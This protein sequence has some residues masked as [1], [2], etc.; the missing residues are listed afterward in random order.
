M[1]EK[2]KGFLS[3]GL[4]MVRVRLNQFQQPIKWIVIGYLVTVFLFVVSYYGFWMYLAVTGKIQLRTFWPWCG[5]W[6]GLPW[7]GSSPL[8]QA[9][10]W[11]LMETESRIILK[12]RRIRN[13]DFY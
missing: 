13:E 10:L 9:A 6:W 4:D 5:N 8:L 2:V 7:W 12:R 1:F 11:I 3:K